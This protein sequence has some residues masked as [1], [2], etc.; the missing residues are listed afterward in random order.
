M[1]RYR[2]IQVDTTAN[3]NT[4]SQYLIE[5]KFL[6]WWFAF[7]INIAIYRPGKEWQVYLH[8]E[9][10]CF[11]HL[12]TAREVLDNILNPLNRFK[13]KGHT[14]QRVLTEYG[15]YVYI[16]ISDIIYER[17][18]FYYRVARLKGDMIAF[19]DELKPEVRKK[20]VVRTGRKSIYT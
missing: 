6:F 4:H 12:T 9:Y 17:K 13:H 11:N 10:K 2:I 14:V 5:K 1:T 18:E 19:I 20:V 3:G 15:D 7:R 16:D 8:K